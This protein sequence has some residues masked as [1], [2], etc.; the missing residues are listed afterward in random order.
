MKIE[1]W[2]DYICPFC[3]IGE[4]KL[5]AALEQTGMK[6]QV[7]WEFKSFELDQNSPKYYGENINELMAKKYR[8]SVEQA[9]KAN[10]N[11]IN[12]AKEAGLNFNF[13]DLKPTNTFDAH[14]LSHYAKAKGKMNEFSEA[15]MKSYFVDSKDI[16]DFNVLA[17]IANDI[18]LDKQKA[19]EVLNSREFGEQVRADEHKAQTIG[20]TGVPYFLFDG[21]QAVY[22]AQPVETFA[23]V[24]SELSKDS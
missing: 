10:N 7:E 9:T 23:E 19:L 17:A 3:Y 24:I 20:V 12:A 6:E 13:D 8:L 21:N 22:G 14:R 2:S 16:S 11:I 1:I 18:G 15:V 5:V 4:R